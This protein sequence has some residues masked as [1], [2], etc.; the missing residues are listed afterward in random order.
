MN[1]HFD[2]SGLAYEYDAISLEKET[3][4]YVFSE[5]FLSPTAEQIKSHEHMIRV[6]DFFESGKG[7]VL[8]P[9][10]EKGPKARSVLKAL[11]Q[12]VPAEYLLVSDGGSDE[13]ARQTV[14]SFGVRLPCAEEVLQAINWDPLLA[15]LNM[16]RFPRA[17][18]GKG[19]NVLAG[20]LLIY[21]L[22]KYGGIKPEWIF[23]HDAEIAHCEV[24]RGLEHLIWGIHQREDAQ[25]VKIAK[26]GRGNQECMSAR[27][28]LICLSKSESVQLEARKRALYY[29]RSIGGDKWMLTGEFGF[30][31]EVAMNRLFASG[32]LE[33]TLAA[34]YAPRAIQVENLNPRDD[35]VNTPQ[36]ES[37]MQNQV[38][39]C[40]IQLA[41][42]APLVKDWTLRDIQ[43][44]NN[45][46][47]ADPVKGGW[48]PDRG[49]VRFE[50][51][52]NNRFLPSIRMLEREG[53]IEEDYL[54]QLVLGL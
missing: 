47:M 26:S 10:R 6:Q 49:P 42:D 35:E 17:T 34:L 2:R 32:Y 24:Y 41:L 53:L 9:M 18:D 3:T 36:K 20:Y 16:D 13:I 15:L 48:I 50:E 12:L 23:Q 44:V 43:S 4:Q 54:K 29:Y 25:Y 46:I 39:Q 38:G 11:T 1:G 33:E 40:I 31:Y 30:Q 7:I 51:V 19:M 8:I 27:N 21:G 5:N 14:Q 22:V 37:V 52:R 28:V 45:K